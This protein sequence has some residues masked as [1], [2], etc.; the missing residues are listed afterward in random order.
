LVKGAPTV[1]QATEPEAAKALLGVTTPADG[2]VAVD[3]NPT[4]LADVAEPARQSYSPPQP[5]PTRA[6]ENVSASELLPGFGPASGV[7]GYWDDA[8]GQQPPQNDQPREQTPGLLTR[9]RAGIHEWS[10]HTPRSRVVITVVSALCVL[11]AI[12]ATILVLAL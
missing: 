8:N 3:T 9:M 7:G 2:S 10:N 5:A 11:A 4:S 12:V 6:W 1:S